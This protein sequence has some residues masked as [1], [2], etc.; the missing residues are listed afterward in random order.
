MVA[1]WRDVWVDQ[2]LPLYQETVKRDNDP[3]E[4]VDIQGEI[5]VLRGL[6][7]SF[8]AG[9]V[10]VRDEYEIARKDVETLRPSVNAVVIVGLPGIGQT[11]YFFT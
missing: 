10:M 8:T 1:F 11:F 4:D 7:S 6:P 3:A 5:K 9:G 2:K